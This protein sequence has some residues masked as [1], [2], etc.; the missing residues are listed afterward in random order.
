MD[1]ILSEPGHVFLFTNIKKN[2]LDKDVCRV[3]VSSH[4]VGR[5]QGVL[6]FL[7]WVLLCV[8]LRVGRGVLVASCNRSVVLCSAGGDVP[9]VHL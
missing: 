2:V 8:W 6:C 5:L 7:V 1:I 3:D 4:L 9:E